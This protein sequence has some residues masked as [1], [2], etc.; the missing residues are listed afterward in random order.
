MSGVVFS[1]QTKSHISISCSHF[2]KFEVS[3]DIAKR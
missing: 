2:L 1:E 3:G